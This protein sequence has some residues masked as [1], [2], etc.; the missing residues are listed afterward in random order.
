MFLN[1]QGSTKSVLVVLMFRAGQR[2]VRMPQSVLARL[3]LARRAK[4]CSVTPDI[5]LEG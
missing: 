1:W 3:P 5:Q 4:V 2:M